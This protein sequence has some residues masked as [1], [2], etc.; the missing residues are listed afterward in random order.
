MVAIDSSQSAGAVAL[1]HAHAAEA[2]GR[3]V[4]P[5]RFTVI[6]IP[7]MRRRSAERH[8]Q[9]AGAVDAGSVVRACESPASSG[10][11]R[12]RELAADEQRYQV[13]LRPA[14]A[15]AARRTRPAPTTSPAA[16]R[17]VAGRLVDRRSSICTNRSGST[18]RRVGL[19][20]PD[21]LAG[22]LHEHC[23]GRDHARR[24]CCP[25]AQRAVEHPAHDV[26]AAVPVPVETRARRD[27][28]LVDADDRAE[29]DVVGVVVRAGREASAT[30]RCR[31]LAA[32]PVGRAAR[33]SITVPGA[34][35]IRGPRQ[36]IVHRPG[37]DD[38]STST[39]QRAARSQP[40]TCQSS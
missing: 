40:F 28:V 16:P 1:A 17:P 5:P 14:R 34:R 10:R 33:I 39:P 12:R 21:A 4:R 3:N 15:V 13:R 36:Q 38:R 7:R 18:V 6:V 30:T 25:R 19:D 35:V 23:T 11:C 31:R 8:E 9:L 26:H 29:R 24:R 37:V 27:A 32:E 20:V 2:L 22:R